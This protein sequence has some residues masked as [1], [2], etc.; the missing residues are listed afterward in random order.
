MVDVKASNNKLVD[1]ARR[2]YQTVLPSTPLSGSEIEALIEK[3]GGSVKTATIVGKSGRSVDEALSILDSVGGSLKRAL[4]LPSS[5]DTTATTGS[6]TGPD[7]VASELV[8]CIDAGGSRCKAVIA[9]QEGIISR[10]ESG[11]CNL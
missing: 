6:Q 9:N 3:C 10:A 5:Q 8:L 4:D 2:I 1:R 7:K 11:P